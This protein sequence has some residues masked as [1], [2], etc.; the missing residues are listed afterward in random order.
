MNFRK[1]LIPV[2]QVTE[3]A[4]E[5]ID[6][7]SSSGDFALGA[8]SLGAWSHSKSKTLSKCSLKFLL[9]YIL[10]ISVQDTGERDDTSSLRHIGTAAHTILEL[11][12]QGVDLEDAYGKAK[13]THI[14]EV[15]EEYWENVELLKPNIR[16]FLHRLKIFE[17]QNPVEVAH[18]ELKVAVDKDWN[19]VHFFSKD[20]FYRGVIDLPIHL[21]NNDAVILDHK[22]GGNPEFGLRNYMDQL[23]SY[24]A[25]FMFG[26][27]RV[28]GIAPGIHFIKEG[29]IVIGDRKPASY[30]EKVPDRILAT[31][32]SSIMYVEDNNKFLHSRNNLCKYCDFQPICHGGKRGTSNLLEDVVEHSKELL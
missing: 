22:H 26:V 27:E 28:D 15:T 3:V 31:I 12:R 10:K 24:G 23:D 32:K 9:E 20:A 7:L 18:T 13:E 16:E 2:E 8:Y 6:E 1:A 17:M 5:R 4:H 14:E 21:K 19:P 30:Y 11:A 25:L 29:G